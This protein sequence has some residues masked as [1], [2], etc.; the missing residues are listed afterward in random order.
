VKNYEPFFPGPKL[1]FDNKQHQGSKAT[2]LARV[3]K[4]RWKLVAENLGY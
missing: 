3:E 2:F 1:T 4:G